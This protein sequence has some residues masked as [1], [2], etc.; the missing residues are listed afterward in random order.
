M[1]EREAPS[2]P[3]ERAMAAIWD[4]VLGV[5]DVGLDEDFFT[6]GGHSMLAVT[7]MTRIRRRFGAE[8]PLSELFR[9]PTVRQL[10]TR[11]QV[12]G[13]REEW[14][15]LVALQPAGGRVPIFFVH[16]VGG[17]VICYSDLARHF[18]PEQPFYALQAPDL[19]Q[20]GDEEV[21]LEEMAANYVA[22]I[23][24]VWPRGPYLLGGWSY[25]GSVAFEM[26]QQLVRAGDEVPLLLLLD[27]S[28]PDVSR[29]RSEVEES[30][31]LH[32][33]AHEEAMKAGREITLTAAELR[34]LDPM[35]RVERVLEALRE[36][37]VVS[38][39]IEASWVR[40]ILDATGVRMRAVEQYEARPYPGKIAVFQPA[41]YDTDPELLPLWNDS[42]SS[43]WRAYSTEPVE[44]HVVPGHHATMA[45]GRYAAGMAERL[46]AVIDDTLS[47]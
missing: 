35:A 11:V 30:V 36:A 6:L 29:Q 21:S 42:G 23:R 2:T 4:E 27:T 12:E 28:T 17:Q 38:A 31:I 20:V 10:S 24:E 39:D 37:E 46:R 47:Y 44:I 34:P 5:Q 9:H 33:L 16:P 7:L 3:A 19:T 43:G 40:R 22:A 8:L 25:G 13:Q 1:E 32:L 15:H 45:A 14:S 41:E 26:A 18:A